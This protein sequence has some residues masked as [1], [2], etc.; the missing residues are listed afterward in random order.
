MSGY[1]KCFGAASPSRQRIRGESW[2]CWERK[3]QTKRNGGGWEE[4]KNMYRW[5][6]LIFLGLEG[7][8]IGLFYSD[9][10][11]CVI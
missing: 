6:V 10:N 7:I 2:E 8:I 3:G 5:N 1:S 11:V 9:Q 4:N